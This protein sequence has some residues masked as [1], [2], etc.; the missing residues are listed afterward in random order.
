MT[1]LS[2]AGFVIGQLFYVL[3]LENFMNGIFCSFHSVVRYGI[4]FWGSSTNSYKVF[5]LQKRIIPGTEP[6]ASCRGLFRSLQILPVP[7]QYILSLMLFIIGNPNNFQTVSEVHG[8]H[9][10]SRNQ[11]FIPNTNLTSVGKCYKAALLGEDDK[12]YT[13]LYFQWI[14]VL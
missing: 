6:R 7:C 11:L 14:H 12:K 9:T 5:K 3:N 4:I 10:R 8:P 1:K 13:V 2:T